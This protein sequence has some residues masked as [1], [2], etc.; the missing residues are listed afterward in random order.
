MV[1]DLLVV[2][3][4]CSFAWHIL[5]TDR[6]V[7]NH[8]VGALLVVQLGVCGVFCFVVAFTGG[9]LQIPRSASVWNALAVTA[10]VASALGFFV[11]TYAQRHASPA[12]TALI[13]ASEPAFAGLFAYLLADETLSALGWLG[14]ALILGSIVAVEAV[15]YLRPVRPLPEG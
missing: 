10:I 6:G 14:A 3:T 5:V 8:D 4:A 13:L 12:R 2:I 1:G 15:P 7:K 9:D 11:Q